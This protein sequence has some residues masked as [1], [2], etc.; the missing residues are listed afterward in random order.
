[1]TAPISAALASLVLPD[2]YGV[3]RRLSEFW[4]QDPAVF[5]FLRHYG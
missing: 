4:K 3:E 5:V 2:L 1:M